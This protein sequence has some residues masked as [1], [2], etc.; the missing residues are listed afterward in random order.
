LTIDLAHQASHQL[1]ENTGRMA[2][3]VRVQF[4]GGMVV[5]RHNTTRSVAVP[6]AVGVVVGLIAGVALRS[7]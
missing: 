7:R 5:V 1:R 2:D 4:N 6:F 3:E